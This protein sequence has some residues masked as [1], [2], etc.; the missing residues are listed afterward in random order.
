MRGPRHRV[1][2]DRGDRSDQGSVSV[3]LVTM[4]VLLLIPVIYLVIAIGQVQAATFATDTAAR[5][6]V[7][8]IVTAERLRRDRR[9]GLFDF[10]SSLL[11]EQA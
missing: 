4:V 8:A 10:V 9:P 11:D 7:R 2:R 5:E 6:A 3:E 1:D